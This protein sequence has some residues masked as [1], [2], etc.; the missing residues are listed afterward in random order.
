MPKKKTQIQVINEFHKVHGNRYDYSLVNYVN[1]S[2]KIRVICSVHGEFEIDPGHHKNGSG[3]RQCYFESQRISKEEFIQRAEK[4]FGDR[5]DYSLFNKLPKNGDQIKILCRE[6]NNTFFQDPKSH[7]RGHTGCP[8]CLSVMLAGSQEERGVFKTKESLTNKFIEQARVIHDDK[9]DYSEFEYLK[10]N[11]KGKIL[12]PKHGEFWQSPSNHLRGSNCPN[13]SRENQQKISF[14]NQ[15]QELGVDYWR[16]LKRREA[17]LPEEKILDPGYVRNSR[18]TSVIRVFRVNYP[19]LEEAVRCLNPPASP[20]AIARWIGKGMSPEEAFNRI[21]NPGYAEGI[22]Y[23]ITHKESSKQYVGLTTQSL[24]RRWKYHIEQ[25]FSGYIKSNKSLHHAIREYGVDAF[26]ISQ[27]D[28][29]TSKKDLEQKEKEWIKKLGTLSPNGYNISTGGVSGG[30]NK[31]SV[32]IDDI[33]FES[34]G[35]AAIYLSQSRN[36]SLSAAN[37]RISQNKIDVKTPAKP[38][39]S[40][41]KTKAYKSWSRIIHGAINPKSKDYIPGLEIYPEWYDFKQFL[42]DV[43]NPPKEG[44]AFARLDKER[45]FFPDNCAWLTKSEASVI[46]AEYMK[47]TGKF[48]RRASQF[49]D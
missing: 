14:K 49:I 29:G 26:E 18:E 20:H 17:G 46:N 38:G 1:S 41:I 37:K 32:C 3:C 16:A 35:E 2:T 28:Q 45:G 23:L 12:C 36:I 15:C 30:S 13:C 25:A 6:H 22:I 24:D 19:N 27:I 11:T 34:V 48:K 43:G 21:P 7:V 5:Y 40:L 8:E 47:R 39:E 4:H 44:M 31:K 10:A 42:Q 9:Y 33:R